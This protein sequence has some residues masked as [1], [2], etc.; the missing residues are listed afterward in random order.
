M[1]PE[2]KAVNAVYNGN[3]V[4]CTT[5]EWPSVRR[6]LQD[7]AGKWIDQGQG[8]RAQIALREVKRMDEKHRG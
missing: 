3:L 4:D 2:E 6:A 5:E 1:T 8:M 7:Q